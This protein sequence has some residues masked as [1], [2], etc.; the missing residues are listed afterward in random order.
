MTAVDQH[1]QLYAPRTAM[2]KERIQRRAY[3]S[4][5]VENIVDQNDVAPATSKPMAP[6]TTTGRISRVE[7][8]SR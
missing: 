6:G 7:R 5:G 1:Q 2:V 8:S 4:A 3:G